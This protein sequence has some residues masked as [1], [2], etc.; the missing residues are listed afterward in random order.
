MLSLW[1]TWVQFL[2]RDLRSHKAYGTAEKKTKKKDLNIEF[3][4]LEKL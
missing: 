2:V 4:K 1:M 3:R